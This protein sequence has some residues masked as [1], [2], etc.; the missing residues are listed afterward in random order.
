[1]G[2]E[3]VGVVVPGTGVGFSHIDYHRGNGKQQDQEFYDEHVLE[4][5]R[6]NL[7]CVMNCMKK[8]LIWTIEIAKFDH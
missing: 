1:M 7:I 3:S 5:W 4:W 2:D 8:K 6:S